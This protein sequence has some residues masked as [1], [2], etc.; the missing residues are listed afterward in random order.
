M[1]VPRGTNTATEIGGRKYTG[2]A[3][4]QMQGRGMT[5]SVVEDTIET[6]EV[7]IK[8]GGTVNYTTD[9]AEVVTN[10]AGDVITTWP[11]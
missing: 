11:R 6:G 5:P 4:D 7:T 10:D 9:Q 2:H 8:K 3:Q 1:D